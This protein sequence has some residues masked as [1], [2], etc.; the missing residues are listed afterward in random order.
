[1]KLNANSDPEPRAQGDSGSAV[2][3]PQPRAVSNLAI[4]LV[5]VLFL[6][7]LIWIWTDQSVWP[8]D[9]SWYGETTVDLFAALGA[10]GDEW[11][12]LLFT[13][14]P[15]R[16]PGLIW[17]GQFFVPIGQWLGRPAF[18]L[19]FCNFI[20]QLTSALVLYRLLLEGFKSRYIAITTVALIASGPLFAGMTHSY[21]TEPFQGLGIVLFLYF[22]RNAETM[23]P[24]RACLLCGI[25]LL[26]SIFGKIT[27]PSYLIFPG[28]LL[29]YRLWKDR[30]S[31][32]EGWRT[33]DACLAAFMIFGYSIL[34]AWLFHNYEGVLAHAAF[35][36]KSTLYG[37][38]GTL[39]EKLALWLS[40]VKSAYLHPW[41]FV[42][43]IAA[44]GVAVLSRIRDARA[45]SW[46][47]TIVAA[48]CLQAAATVVLLALNT[49][50]DH[51][52]IF[53]LFP[54]LGILI[55]WIFSASRNLPALAGFGVA[56]FGQYLLVSS[57]LLG[58]VTTGSIGPYAKP[59]DRSGLEMATV[60]LAVGA[61]CDSANNRRTFV[62]GQELPQ[63]NAN[64]LSFYSSLSNSDKGIKC[65]FASLGYA[66]Q[67]PSRAWKN[68]LDR[69]PRGILFLERE[70]QT[71]AATDPFNQVSNAI[72][73]R[74]RNSPQFTRAQL[75]LDRNLLLFAP[76]TEN[77]WF[78]QSALFSSQV[79]LWG[80]AAT[81]AHWLV[82]PA[83]RSGPERTVIA[84]NG[85][86]PR[87]A[88][89][90]AEVDSVDSKCLGMSMEFD[91]VGSQPRQV[92][93]DLARPHKG[94][95]VSV[96]LGN[97]PDDTLTVQL[98]SLDSVR[99]NVEYCWIT[100]RNVSLRSSGN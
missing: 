71:L 86:L 53:S 78:V 82:H 20:L 51:R 32:R 50:E 55:G 87:N 93:A 84:W 52:F 31:W 92:N 48:C 99:D 45:T 47:N 37:H 12:R 57:S 64:T 29:C 39:L 58:F 22:L 13:I 36:S 9:P 67:D 4:G 60:T 10:S 77:G 79:R 66:E 91:V 63:F 61:T 94:R 100:F 35:S 75:S 15:E 11:L 80:D 73:D 65:Y 14:L 59:V 26:I 88:T 21:F 25:A 24:L 96:A 56:G 46:M 89:F 72:L 76:R 30:S 95:I 23:P 40:Q 34:A 19:L 33:G 8:W 17:L 3:P 81:G 1:M 98:K 68:M 27:S 62:V 18:G 85:E 41:I 28:A 83:K 90:E 44:A 70:S 16:T 49:N 54:H 69:Q 42:L 7:S 74:V 43:F 97:S 2:R 38:P 5:F 6:P